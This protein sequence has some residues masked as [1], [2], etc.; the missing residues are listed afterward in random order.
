M[1]GP[2]PDM[3][4]ACGPALPWPALGVPPGEDARAAHPQSGR[5][6]QA[7]PDASGPVSVQASS[8][9]ESAQLPDGG[10]GGRVL[11][12]SRRQTALTHTCHPLPGTWPP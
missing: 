2:S 12:N 4:A 11:S 6:E 5:V 7:E 10:G 1:C 9:Q 8:A 3:A